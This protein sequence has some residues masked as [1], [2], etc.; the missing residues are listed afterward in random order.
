[1]SARGYLWG[2]KID[3]VGL[4][5]VQPHQH[6][7]FIASHKDIHAGFCVSA[8]NGDQVIKSFYQAVAQSACQ[9]ELSE[10]ELA[11]FNTTVKATIR[12]GSD[13]EGRTAMADSIEQE[14]LQNERRKELFQCCVLS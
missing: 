12:I 6:E 2:N 10:N 8:Q 13:D 4:R 9:I 1:M 11:V 7:A 14:D 3:L 5:K